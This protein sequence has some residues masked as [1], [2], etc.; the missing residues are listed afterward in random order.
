MKKIFFY[1]LL[2]I[3]HTK[4]CFSME[5]DSVAAATINQQLTPIGGKGFCQPPLPNQKHERPI[6]QI[7][8]NTNCD[9]PG[10][11]HVYARHLLSSQPYGLFRI[12]GKDIFYVLDNNKLT[13]EP[14]EKL[15]ENVYKDLDNAIT[16]TITFAKRIERYDGH[17]NNWLVYNN[18]LE[19][20]K[21][22][23]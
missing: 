6:A 8:L 16:R 14:V 21:P 11:E 12:N 10:T 23:K 2:V 19:I 17:K 7:L 20:L 18:R 3:V 22:K 1:T 13:P 9:Q 4:S 15:P 5:Q